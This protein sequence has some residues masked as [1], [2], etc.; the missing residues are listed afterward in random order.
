MGIGC[1][2]GKDGEEIVV[3]QRRGGLGIVGGGCLVVAHSRGILFFARLVGWA[4]VGAQA[5]VLMRVILVVSCVVCWVIV[6]GVNC[7][8]RCQVDVDNHSEGMVVRRLFCGKRNQ[9]ALDDLRRRFFGAEQTRYHYQNCDGAFH[10]L[11]TRLS[12]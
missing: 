8:K 2:E 7:V 6:G 5:K 4:N 12:R 3:F 11:E 1:V 10:S 9:S